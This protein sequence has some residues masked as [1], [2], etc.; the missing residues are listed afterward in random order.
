M[1][2]R[3]ALLALLASSLLTPAMAQPV[4]APAPGT[5]GANVP[6]HMLPAQYVTAYGP[7]D[8]AEVK[9]SLD[10]V[11]AYLAANTPVELIDRTTRAPVRIEDAGAN[12]DFKPGDFRI[13]SYEWGV[14][15]SGM[16]RAAE[17]TGDPRYAEYTRERMAFIAKVADQYRGLTAAQPNLRT[18]V[19]SVLAPRALDDIGAMAAAMIRTERQGG[20]G[21]SLRPM[22]DNGLNYISTKEFRLADGTLARN[23]PLPDTLWLDDLY[24]SVPALAQM[25][26]LTGERRYFDDA[27]KQI[28][29]FSARMFNKDLGLYMHGWVQGMD[30]HP[31]FH[32]GRANG[33]AALAMSDLLDVLPADHPDRPF[34]LKQLQAHIAGIQR[35]Q[36]G[37]G[38]WHQ[39]IDRPD[40]YE[41]TSATAIF[42]Y[43]IA[44]A[45]NQGWIDAKAYGPT[46]ILGWHAISTKINAKGQVEDVCVGTGMAFDPA[47]YYH[48]PVNVLAA[49]GYGPVL[50]AGAEVIELARKTPFV[51]N[52]SAVMFSPAGA[53][54]RR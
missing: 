35:Y 30:T 19:R 42:T 8:E 29:Q 3:T 17:V 31:E 10:R 22:I 36:S 26:A 16:L 6:L 25:G 49:H 47:F 21:V 33:W 53:N 24:M 45:A 12:S 7:I 48:R 54:A 34:I 5:G 52:D 28:K 15:Y 38:F 13:Y 50:L 46:A 20:A 2:R 18:P 39:L 51:I 27:A 23:R 11:R 4:Q 40:S 43:V 32:W 14:T 9:A 1:I 44:H 37:S 41:E